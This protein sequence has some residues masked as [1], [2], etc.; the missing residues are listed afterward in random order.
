MNKNKSIIAFIS[1]VIWLSFIYSAFFG[2]HY[3]YAGFVVFFWLALSTLNYRH[4]TSVW[5][6]K[7]RFRQFVKFYFF[8][9]IFGI[10]ADFVVGQKLTHLWSY[11]Y[12]SSALDWIKLYVIIY[13]VGALSVIELIYFLGN[14]FKEKFVLVHKQSRFIDDLEYILDITLAILLLI[15]ILS[16]LFTTLPHIGLILFALLLTWLFVATLKFKYHIR[17]WTHWVAILL[18]T[19][20]ISLFLHEIPNT[21]VYEWRYY[22]GPILN[23]NILGIPLWVFFG[24]YLLILLIL[25]F[26]MYFVIQKRN[27]K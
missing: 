22:P 8:L 1:T 16:K 7:N 4:E 6:L 23:Q 19:L 20:F 13:P 26:W 27:S 2:F 11:Q 10:F 9:F 5:L 3:W 15:Y 17:H 21:A 12:Y 18:T 14:L 24:W 25:R